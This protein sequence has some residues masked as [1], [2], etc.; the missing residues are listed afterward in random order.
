MSDATATGPRLDPR[1]GPTPSETEPA[2]FSS[3]IGSDPW[4][5]SVVHDP[6]TGSNDGG[7]P[8]RQRPPGRRHAGDLPRAFHRAP[9]LHERVRLK[10]AGGFGEVQT[11]KV[12][13]NGEGGPKRGWN[14]AT[15]NQVQRICWPP[16]GSF[17]NRLDRSHDGRSRGRARWRERCSE[18]WSES[19][20]TIPLAGSKSTTPTWRRAARKRQTGRRETRSRVS[21]TGRHDLRGLAEGRRR[22]RP[23]TRAS[24]EYLDPRLMTASC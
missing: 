12:V 23:D 16:A 17:G 3:E 10:N 18:L 20:R 22:S 21:D 6:R 2:H 11:V 14:P 1:E 4:I 15:R 19:C 9:E 7:T 8:T 5:T 24:S 13:R